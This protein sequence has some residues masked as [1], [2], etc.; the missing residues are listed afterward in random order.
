MLKPICSKLRV[1][2]NRHDEAPRLR[3]V[4]ADRQRA[5]EADQ[6]LGVNAAKL[7]ERAKS[8]ACRRLKSVGAHGEHERHGVEEAAESENRVSDRR[9][10]GHQ[11]AER[12]A[13]G[14]QRKSHARAALMAARGGGA[15]QRAARRAEARTSL[16]FLASEKP[17]YFFAE[18][19]EFPAPAQRKGQW[20]SLLENLCVPIIPENEEEKLKWAA[21]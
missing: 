14:G 4:V 19:V 3:E 12:F 10:R 17:V 2:K 9:S 16:G 11:A 8:A 20:T 1:E 7:K 13:C 6:Y 5:A 15:D 18:A 21:A